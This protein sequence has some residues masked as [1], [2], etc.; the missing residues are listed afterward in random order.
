MT[1]NTDVGDEDDIDK[2][3]EDIGFW[4]IKNERKKNT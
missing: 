1:E 4:R 3:L 2:M